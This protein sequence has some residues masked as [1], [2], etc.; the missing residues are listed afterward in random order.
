MRAFRKKFVIVF[1]LI[2][3][4]ISATP[5]LIA[6]ND[7]EATRELEVVFLDVG[8]GDAILV[9]TP[10]GSWARWRSPTTPTTPRW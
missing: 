5:E 10:S 9:T 7:G 4:A 3:L 8:Q 2:L 1:L 6:A